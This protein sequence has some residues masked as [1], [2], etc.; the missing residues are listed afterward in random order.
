M[1]TDECTVQLEHHSRLC[2]RKRFQPRVLKQRAKHPIKIHLWGGISK[3]GYQCHYVYRGRTYM[4]LKCSIIP[5]PLRESFK[6]PVPHILRKSFKSPVPHILRKSF[7]SPVPP[8]IREGFKSSSNDHKT[9]REEI[10][11]C[12]K[13]HVSRFNIRS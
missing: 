7:K 9:S 6:S 10:V 13:C 11:S 1:F 8:I 4:Y 3:R 12:Q 5:Y 2:F